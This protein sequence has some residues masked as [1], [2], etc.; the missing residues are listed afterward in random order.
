MFNLLMP[1]IKQQVII[2]YL[3]QLVLIRLEPSQVELHDLILLA[4]LYFMLIIEVLTRCCRVSKF[5]L[6]LTFNRIESV[7]IISNE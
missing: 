5:L 3:I 2:S 7:I 6:I 4:I 1:F